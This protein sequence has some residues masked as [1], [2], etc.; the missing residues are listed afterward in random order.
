MLS[1]TPLMLQPDGDDQDEFALDHDQSDASR[2]V[3]K[4]TTASGALVNPAQ[5]DKYYDASMLS[6]KEF[7]ARNPLPSE[8]LRIHCLTSRKLGKACIMDKLGLEKRKALTLW[9][10]CCPGSMLPA[11]GTPA[12]E[13]TVASLRQPAAGGVSQMGPRETL[14]AYITGLLGGDAVAAEI[15]LC[16]LL[17]KTYELNSRMMNPFGLLLG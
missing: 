3:K 11:H 16:Y 4:S 17:S 1:K 2:P 12:F 7:E 15:L 8:A 13:A 10:V 9:G 5:Q 6:Q 14:L